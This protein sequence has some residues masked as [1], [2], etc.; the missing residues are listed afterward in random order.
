V[1]SE[2]V[3]AVFALLLL[4]GIPISI[5][6]LVRFI[7]LTKHVAEIKEILMSALNIEAYGAPATWGPKGQHTQY[8]KGFR[9]IVGG[10][11]HANR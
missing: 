8:S 10:A 4:V 7:R 5:W 9:R 2:T 6:V 3:E 1:S 11:V